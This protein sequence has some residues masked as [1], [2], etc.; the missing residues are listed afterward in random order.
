MTWQKYQ[1][2][3]CDEVKRVPESP[4]TGSQTINTGCG[5]C[6]RIQTHYAV[7]RTAW[8]IRV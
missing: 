1:C 7:G 3:L 5:S 6:G 2:G 4:T 8:V